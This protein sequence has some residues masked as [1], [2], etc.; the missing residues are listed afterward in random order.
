MNQSERT[1][2]LKAVIQHIKKRRVKYPIQF[3][4]LFEVAAEFIIDPAKI[5]FLMGGN[6]SSKTTTLSYYINKKAEEKPNMRIWACSETFSD[7]VNI[8]QRKVWQLASKPKISYGYYND[9]TGFPNRKLKWSNGSIAIFKSY[10][11]GREAYQGD[12]V[13]LIVNDEE[14]PYDIYL[15]QRMRLVDRD[16]EML[17]AMTS[18]KGMTDL[19]AD[20]YE[21]SNIIKSQ[22]A[23]Y[24]DN[25]PLPRIS[26]KNGIK[27]YFLWTTENKFISQNRLEQ[28]VK[29]MDTNEIKSRIYGLP[30]GV[31]LRI[32]PM[33][34]DK[35]HVMR[36]EDIPDTKVTLYHVCD[37]H[38][39]KP[40]AMQWWAVHKT[41]IKYC[42]WEYP[43]KR[44]FNDMEYDDKTYEDYAKVIDDIELQL[45]EIF[46]R[47]VSK[48]FIDPNFGNKTIQ[49][50]VRT[51]GQSKT[52]VKKEM[53]KLGYTFQDSIDALATGHIAVKNALHWAE[54]DGELVTRPEIYIADH[55]ENTIR[56][57]SRYSFN[58]IE[59]SEGDT[60][61]VAK[62]KD[63]YKDFA[64]TTRYFIMS[65]PVYLEP[66]IS[67]EPE[68]NKLY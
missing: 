4:K 28:E 24:L 3:I 55:C 45:T 48:R 32:Y 65:N 61:D 20:L 31:A 34:S 68:V 44:N 30:T 27:F 5:K 19:L 51:Q 59:T 36:W 53:A 7:S 2:R 60:K 46:G 29:I 9:I 49:L 63:K 8:L 18:V 21:N 39:R 57:L 10:D 13:D 67:K 40:W 14:P 15:E 58:D 38:D 16:G 37:P 1:E 50:A 17:F 12:D 33:F 52:T 25:Q 66:K 26:E 56:H 22:Q 62:P 54:K 42:I 64:D 6:R 43:Y 41:G 47:R 11:Q 23:K 35:V